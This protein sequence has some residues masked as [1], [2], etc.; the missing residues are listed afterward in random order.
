MV[1]I[2]DQQLDEAVLAFQVDEKLSELLVSE[3]SEIQPAVFAFLFTENTELFTEYEKEYLLF[4]LLTLWQAIRVE[5][6]VNEMEEID[7]EELSIAEEKNWELL[8]SVTAN[9]FRDRLDIFFEDNKQSDLLAFIEDMLLDEEDELLTKEGREP[10]F[11]I[12]KSIIDCLD[13]CIKP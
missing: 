11:V 4:I 9:R 3:L 12:L 2:N 5:V 10:M 8:E 6:D 7:S 1:F 13:A